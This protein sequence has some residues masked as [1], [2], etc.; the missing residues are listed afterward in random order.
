VSLRKRVKAYLKRP[1]KTIRHFL[2]FS[3]FIELF[4]FKIGFIKQPFSNNKKKTYIQIGRPLLVLNEKMQSE[5]IY[6]FNKKKE[7]GGD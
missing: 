5:F 7:R 3:L 6:F 2:F 4:S 1:K